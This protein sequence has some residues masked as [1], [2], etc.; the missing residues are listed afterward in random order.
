MTNLR[1]LCVLSVFLSLFSCDKNR[2]FDQYQNIAEAWEKDEIVEFVLPEMDA[3]EKYN[4]FINIRNNNS[5]KYSNLF[6]I[7]KMEFPNGKMVTD[8]LEYQMAA[9]D[10]Q[11][12]G[13]GFSDTKESRLWYKENVSF[14]EEGNYKIKLQHAM[15]KNGEVAGI[16]TLDGIT[17]IG[18]RI[19]YAQKP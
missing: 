13:E 5:Y 16:N 17:D 18:F 1:F 6:I 14:A 3:Q 2:F 8:T 11:W 12:L 7:S 4:L 10:G 15:R 9:P 19:E